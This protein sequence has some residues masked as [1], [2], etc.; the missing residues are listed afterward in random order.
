VALDST[1][2]AAH[3]QLGEALNAT[4]RLAEALDAY[5]A[6]A[7]LQPD[8]FRAL[9]KIGMMLDRLRRPEEATA[10]YQRAREVQRR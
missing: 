10:A 7:A 1:K 6:A 9:N 3:L 8:N 2:I 4:D 5:Q